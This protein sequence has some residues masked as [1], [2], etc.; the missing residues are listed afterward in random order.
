MERMLFC[1]DRWPAPPALG[2]QTLKVLGCPSDPTFDTGQVADNSGRRFA[3]SNYAG[4]IQVFCAV[5][6]QGVISELDG[7]ADFGSTF[8]DGTSNTILW[9]EKYARFTNA[10]YPW[11]GSAWAYSETDETQASLHQGFAISWDLQS[12]GPL[13]VPQFRPKP[14]NCVPTRASTAHAGGIQIGLADGSVRS[15]A[16][17]VGGG[18]WWALC[19]PHAG[20]SPAP[21]GKVAPPNLAARASPSPSTRACSAAT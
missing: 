5:P 1:V 2:T 6:D 13:S 15:L 10:K 7:G 11:G 8:A 18:T 14:A 20:D 16:P 21:T 4:N 12:T 3:P 17:S 9:A 19:T